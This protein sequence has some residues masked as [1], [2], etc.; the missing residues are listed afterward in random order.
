MY[1]GLLIFGTIYTYDV[2]ERLQFKKINFVEIQAIVR[3]EKIFV[4]IIKQK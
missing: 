1:I 3:S 2:L 4:H